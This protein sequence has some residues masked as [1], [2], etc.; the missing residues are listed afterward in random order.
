M[1]RSSA[2]ARF[3]V[4]AMAAMANVACPATI[5]GQT[6]QQVSAM[7]RLQVSELQKQI[8]TAEAAHAGA[9]QLATLWIALANAY[10]EVVDLESAENAFAHA[11]RLL[12]VA[13]ASG[14]YAD[15]L[16]GISTVYFATG[17][18]DMA[19]RCLRQ[20]IEIEHAAGDLTA[21]TI[22]RRDLAAALIKER[23]Y[24]E[25]EKQA[26][27]VLRL[28][29]A[30]SH[31]NIREMIVVYLIRSRAT[32]GM[33]RC[34]E[35]LLDV[36]RAEALVLTNIGTDPIDVITIPAL[37][38]MEQF[39]SG[40]VEQGDRTVQQALRLLDSRVD[41]PAPFRI[42]LREALLE[43]YSQLLGSAHRKQEKKKV[44]EEIDRTRAQQPG[45]NTCTVSAASVGLFP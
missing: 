31:P 8:K 15:A 26:S 5:D 9:Q 24:A 11:I 10:K 19:E 20:A 34:E 27:E 37:R 42:H 2:K 14:L 13:G 39:R 38:G 44:D 43:E 35:A 33:R 45:C 41:I 6:R 28:W 23:K 30:Q 32:C 18:A 12:R 36:D 7:S 29:E 22:T 4:I 21:E 25:A 17:R 40:A 3:W 16:D 1:R